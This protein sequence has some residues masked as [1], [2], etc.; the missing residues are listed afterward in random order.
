MKITDEIFQ[1]GGGGL[2]S[3]ED[4]AI[5]LINFGEGAALV[6]A[7]C[8]RSLEK[9]LN[10][11]KTCGVRP[12]QIDYLLITH[13]HYDHTGGTKGIKDLTQCQVVAHEL[14]AQYLEKGDNTVTAA[15]WYGASFEP[16][17]VDRKLTEKE[18][19]IVLGDRHVKA[20]HT[21]GH[22]PGSVVYVAESGGLKVLF[23]QDIHGPLDARMLSNREDYL[24]SLSLLVSLK[25]DILCEGHYGVLRGRSEV[26][27]FITSF[28]TGA[29]G[30]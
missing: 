7:G 26:E 11:M 17:S 25:A 2:T 20:I 30:P 28:V 8:G 1:V 10:N 29:G 4:A 13:C 3:P 19:Q 9:V 21:P 22:S 14:D 5:Y 27:G 18:E 6:D 16:F 12:E 15:I 23:G 24:H